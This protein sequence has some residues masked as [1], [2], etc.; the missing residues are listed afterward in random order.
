M[1]GWGPALGMAFAFSALADLQQSGAAAWRA[2]LG[3][4]LAGCAVGQV[5][6]LVGW[7]PSFLTGV[8]SADDRLPRRVRVR[9][10]DPHGRRD[11][12]VQGTRRSAS[13][14]NRPAKPR[15]ARDDAQRSEAHYRAVVENAAE[16][17][18]TVGPD[19]TIGSFNAAAEA[20]FGWTA[21]EIVGQ[22]VAT[23]V[24]PESARRAR[25]VP[26][27]LPGDRRRP[28]R[29]AARSRPPACGATAPS[30]RWSS[31]RARSPSTG[32]PPIDLGH[33]PRPLRPEAVRGAARRTR[34]CTT[35]SPACRTG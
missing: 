5:L 33:H 2:V 22:P 34:C 30:S 21:S 12:R 28:P 31:R 23:I 25:A 26:R 4:S 18:L 15:A 20:M 6:V 27:A 11:P 8:A 16:G 35:R 17:I 1:S 9:D 3:W 13:S 19:G 10:R 7:A 32:A 24:T 14:P 29:S